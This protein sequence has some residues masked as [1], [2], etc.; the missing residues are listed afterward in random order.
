[1]THKC[2]G[3]F[4]I[5]TLLFSLSCR[6][7]ITPIASSTLRVST[8][9]DPQTLDPRKTR[10]LTTATVIHMLYEGLMRLNEEG[11]PTLAMA[12]DVN[13]SEDQKT[14]TFK[15]RKSSWSN[16][17]PVTAADFEQTWK[18][19][20]NPNF[21]SPNAYQLYPI[22]GAK[23]AKEGKIPLDQVKI[24]ATDSRTLVVELENKTPYF[25]HLISTYF[26]YPVS[27]EMREKGTDSITP[28]KIVSNGPFKFKEWP[29][30]QFTAIKNKDYWNANDIDIDKIILVNVNNSIA[31]SLFDRGELD[32]AGSPL[33][34]IPTDALVALKE[35]N[36]LK[37]TP[38]AGVYLFRFNTAKPPFDQIKV[39]RAFS[40]ALNRHDLVE[41]VLQGNQ[42]PAM[43]LIPPSFIN[44]TPIFRDYNL[45]QAQQLY[46]EALAEKH[47]D[48]NE[49]PTI[50]LCYSNSERNH[51]IAQVAQQ[52]WKEAL[53]V[54]VN[55]QSCESKILYD[56][57][58]NQ[59]YQI[60]IGAWFADIKDPISFLDV[61]KYK[62]NGTNNTQWENPRYVQ[63]LDYSCQTGQH[64]ERE[65]LLREAELVLIDEMPI[66]PLFYNTF[67]YVKKPYVKGVYFC[68]LG[69][70]DFK[71]AYLDY[72]SN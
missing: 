5:L 71:Y 35:D 7:E 14:Y 26:Y 22:K 65:K 10:D 32:W 72:E 56:R 62:N 44:H 15:I 23:E 47:L 20:L 49:L 70:L 58:K 6:R 68:D 36:E 63:L 29:P 40:Y 55:L 53:G 50:T 48:K 11:M 60:A 24:K 2:L 17:T 9:A 37:V 28:E 42:I 31:L 52:Q 45:T 66:A 30:N 33:S 41:H 21:P 64:A 69:Y 25:L 18:S 43:G 59:D 39:R 61:F 13:I 51:K 54:N 4:F 34:T 27:K 16:G 19:V 8:E 12:E 38:A 46:K 57:L 67:N 3:Y 1:M